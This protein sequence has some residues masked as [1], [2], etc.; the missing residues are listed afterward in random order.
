[1]NCYADVIVCQFLQGS[2]SF[3]QA[4]ICLLAITG[5]IMQYSS[6]VLKH[7]AILYGKIHD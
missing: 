3:E 7:A 5:C 6:T 4:F 1:M 2:H